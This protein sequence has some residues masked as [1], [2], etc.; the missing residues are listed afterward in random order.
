MRNVTIELFVTSLDSYQRKTGSRGVGFN[1]RRG[2]TQPAVAP[3]PNLRDLVRL[4]SLDWYLVGLELDLDEG[5]L[6]A[7]SKDNPQD[8]V[9]ARR[10]LYR[11]WLK[12]QPDASYQQLVDALS[13][14]GNESLA[15]EI[16]AMYGKAAHYLVMYA[17][18]SVM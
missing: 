6:E 1:S 3:K 11:L 17:C 15:K 4:P 12:R 8:D 13:R 18:A 7:I 9:K 14:A 5:D 10:E 2:P 16:C